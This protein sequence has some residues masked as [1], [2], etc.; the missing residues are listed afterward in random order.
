MIRLLL[1]TIQQ[2]A[3][4]QRPILCDNRPLPYIEWG[5]IPSIQDF[6]AHIKASIEHAVDPKETYRE[7]DEYIMDLPMLPQMSYK[8][9]TL[10]NRCRLFL[11]VECISDISDSMGTYIDKAWLVPDGPKPSRSTLKWPLQSDPGKEAWAIWR[12]FII[13]SLA[14]DS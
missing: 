7:N 5:W 14:N 1:E 4:I 6:L 8:E 2:E 11:R 9:Q 10:I 12:K 3:G 13:S